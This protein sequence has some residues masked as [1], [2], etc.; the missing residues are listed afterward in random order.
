MSALGFPPDREPCV[1]STTDLE[2]RSDA[3]VCR[4][5][6]PRED[7]LREAFLRNLWH[8]MDERKRKSRWRH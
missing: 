5:R 7:P 2:A 6:E 3:L 4:E 1:M 8:L